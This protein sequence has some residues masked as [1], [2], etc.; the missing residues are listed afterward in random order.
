M[1]QDIRL[2]LR[3]S[4]VAKSPDVLGLPDERSGSPLES[5]Q[6]VEYRVDV[7]PVNQREER[8]LRR[9]PRCW[10]PPGPCRCS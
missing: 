1:E 8:E 5:A 9:D 4:G 7:Q 3:L 10:R 6:A 2:V